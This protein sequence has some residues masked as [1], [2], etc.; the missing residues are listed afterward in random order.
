V[1]ARLPKR[2]FTTDETLTAGSV[3]HFGPADDWCGA[4]LP[5]LG[6]DGIRI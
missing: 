4:H 2:V 5:L 3:A 1:P 6:G